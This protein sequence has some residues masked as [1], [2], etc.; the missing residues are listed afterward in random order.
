ML[1][2]VRRWA[3]GLLALFGVERRFSGQPV[4]WGGGPRLVVANHR[5]PLDI[6][7]LL[8]CFGGFVLARHDLAVWPMLGFAAR[9][10]GTIF[11][12][13]NDARS[14]VKAIREIRKRLVEGHTVIVFPEGTTHAGDE[15]HPFQGGA[16]AAVRGL[17][18]ELLPVGIAYRPGAEFVNEGFGQHVL[19]AAQRARTPVA[20]CVGRPLRANAKREVLA[21]ALRD[22]VQALVHAARDSLG[23]SLNSDRNGA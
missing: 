10:S 15:V 12:D 21:A 20:V 4:R 14:G 7:V 13:R 16:L 8:E 6:I 11:V 17:D 3:A 22:E 9:E 2:W 1:R 19:R 18:V 23:S 5:S